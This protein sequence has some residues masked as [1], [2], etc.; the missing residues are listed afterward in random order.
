MNSKKNAIREF[1]IITFGM[2]LVAAAVYFFMVPSKIVVGSISGLGLVISQ[3]T[4]IQLSVITF[5]LNVVLLVIGFIFIGKEFGAKTVY[6]S[7]LLPVFLWIYE[8][9]IPVTKSVTG[10]PVYD[11]ITYILIVALGQALL[12]H[13]NASSGGIDIVAKII[14]KFTHMEIGKA[15]TAAGMVTAATSLLVYDFA[16]F[17][18]SILGTYAN[19]I[20]VDYFIDGFNKRKRV[21]ILS[22]D[23]QEIQEYI[24]K[25]LNRGV[26]LYEAYGAYDNKKRIELITILTQQEYKILLNY[27]HTNQK[28]VFVTVSTVNEVIGQ[29][30]GK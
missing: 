5:I 3:L 1:F 16:T 4:G 23:Y 17:I 14:N 9:I 27:L 19:G 10:N 22:D 13:V 12:F 30:N 24:M 28:Q 20:A 15:V 26:T 25:E 8:R 21:C 18:V 29:W 2:M 6:T 7:M 11:L